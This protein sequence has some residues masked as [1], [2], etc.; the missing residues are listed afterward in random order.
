MEVAARLQP[1]VVPTPGVQTQTSSGSPSDKQKKPFDPEQLKDEKAALG[2]AR[3]LA[4]AQADTAIHSAQNSASAAAT[5][6]A[7]LAPPR[8][9]AEWSRTEGAPNWSTLSAAAKGYTM[10]ERAINL[11]RHINAMSM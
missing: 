3:E 10:S 1:N 6:R 11:Y 5:D 8:N 2:V 9:N 7:S 4:E